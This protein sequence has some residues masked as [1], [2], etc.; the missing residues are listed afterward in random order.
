[1]NITR[2]ELTVAGLGLMAAGSIGSPATAADGLIADLPEGLDEFALAVEAYIYAY[3]LV[4]MEITRRVITNVV[5]P[6]GTRGPMGHVIKLRQY[7]DAKFRDVT[8]PNADTLYTTA[9]FDVGDEPWVVSL[10]DLKD[11]YA[12][13]PMLDG[14]TT[15]FDVPGKRTTGTGAQTF[16]VTGPGWEGTLPEGVKQYKSST[17]IVWLLGRIY[18]TGTPEDY[19]EVHKLQDEV[20]LYPL[21]AW[22]KDW[23]APKG[24]VD[25]AIDMKTAVR[26]QVNKM[27]AVEY[28][29]LFAELLKSN[30]PTDADAP[31]VAKL[32]EL[33]IVPG[34][35]F[36]KSKFDPAF[37]K[38]VPQVGF[39][40]IMMHFKF[41]DGDIQDIDGWGFTTK[42]GI[43]GTNYIQRALITA[44]GLGANRPQ[45][46][47][48]PT[49]MKSDSG[50]IKRAYNGSEKYV[51]TF[52]KDLTPPVAGFWSLTMYD[53][54]YFFVDNPLNRYS[55]S[56]RQPLKANPDGSIDL[57]I[58][59]ESPGADK[60]S[61]WL[62]APEGKFILMMR[63]Y[64]PNEGNP[65][66]IDGS[67]TIPSVR[68]VS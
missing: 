6:E 15:V 37:A 18:C 60:E 29:T 56:A 41:S 47:I 10:P 28:F 57:F 67:W 31:M 16:V 20:K 11:R 26:E 34:Q 43:Y 44:I 7:P 64:W 45:D 35:D 3:P 61:N 21:S 36:D 30:P 23:T 42:A 1:M 24:K 9:F 5:E 59:H 2:R 62:P 65:S 4:T 46:A 32:A 14:W 27:D 48:Y 58:Q 39:A 22:G 68:K 40:R 66:I 33:G 8:A 25:P 38:R 63:L 19:A 55:I 52:K 17:S 54:G 53:A 13:F 12:L 51:L 49:S 50:V